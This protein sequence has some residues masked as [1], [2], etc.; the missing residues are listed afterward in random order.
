[1]LKRLRLQLTL[2]YILAALSLVLMTGFGSYTLLKFYFQKEIDLALEYKM[3]TQFRQYGLVPPPE[4]LQAEQNWQANMA[5]QSPSPTSPPPT[6]VPT[7]QVVSNHESEGED[8]GGHE[9]E[10][11]YSPT[12]QPG[13]PEE[14]NEDKYN[15]QLASIYVLPI[16]A[17]GKVIQDANQAGL[18]FTQ[19][20]AASQAA[21]VKGHDLRT[22]SLENGTRVRLLTYHLTGPNGSFILQLGRT[23]VDQDQVLSQFLL[24]LIILGSAGSIFLG[25]GSWWLSGRSLGPAQ[26]AWEQQ[27]AFVANASHELRTPLTLIRASAEVGLRSRSEEEQKELLQDILGECDYVNHLVDDLLMLSRLDARRLKLARE[28]VSL[29]ELFE[30]TIQQAEKLATGKGINLRIGNAEGIIS[31]DRTHL[32]QVLLILLDN[33][34]RFTPAGGLIQLAS[35]PKRKMYQIIVSDNGRGIAPEHL[36][37]LFERFYQ[38]NPSGEALIRGNGLGLSIAK[39]IIEAQGGNIHVQSWLGKGTRV[40]LELPVWEKSSR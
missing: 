29:H 10:G 25:L 36:P 9:I 11:A 14:D 33:A 28:P 17:S 32:R 19:D 5:S 20:K 6:A 37:H 39:G 31:G 38:V 27:Q 40:I 23:L 4:L 13:Y 26:K 21:L 8:D 30:E 7:R 24:G 22:I 18:P 34:I 1:M 12:T 3:A 35:N 15:G 16:D 2:L